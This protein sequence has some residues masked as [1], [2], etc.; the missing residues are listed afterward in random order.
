MYLL[1]D[2]LASHQVEQVLS[3]TPP[4]MVDMVVSEYE[5]FGDEVPLDEILI[6]SSGSGDHPQKAAIVN[7]IRQWLRRRTPL[8]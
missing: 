3:N 1:F 7:E 5:K 8:V 6:F 4:S 2:L